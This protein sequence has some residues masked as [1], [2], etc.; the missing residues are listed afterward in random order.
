MKVLRS[1]CLTAL[2]S[3]Q[4]PYLFGFYAQNGF[5]EYIPTCEV[6]GY[7][8][9]RLSYRETLYCLQI[10]PGVDEN[11]YYDYDPF[12]QDWILDGSGDLM[13]WDSNRG[14]KDVLEAASNTYAISSYPRRGI[15]RH[16]SGHYRYQ[17][18]TGF[19]EFI[20]ALEAKIY[21]GCCDNRDKTSTEY[22]WYGVNWIADC[23]DYTFSSGPG[24]GCANIGF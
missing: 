4:A 13:S 22:L 24:T 1:V 6:S 3:I 23:S 20:V 15:W 10:E 5:F 21:S 9:T 12:S 18:S 17:L 14:W 2:I 8:L 16:P 19:Y 11:C 7:A